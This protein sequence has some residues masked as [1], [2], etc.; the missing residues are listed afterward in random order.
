MIQRQLFGYFFYV[1]EAQTF[2]PDDQLT[3]FII[4]F[5][6]RSSWFQLNRNT[7]ALDLWSMFCVLKLA[8]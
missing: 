2:E 1:L 3:L 7:V 4:F 5:S 6:Q 8:L